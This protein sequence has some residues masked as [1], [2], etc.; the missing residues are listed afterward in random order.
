MSSEAN[1]RLNVTKKS[2]GSSPRDSPHSSLISP[3]P[4]SSTSL[5]KNLSSR[6]PRMIWWGI[7]IARVPISHPCRRTFDRL[8]AQ[9]AEALEAVMDKSEPAVHR[10]EQPEQGYVTYER[11][12]S[13]QQK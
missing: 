13:A 7:M 9:L 1:V 12:R 3:G 8:A 6:L 2:S 11:E 5:E 10:H 4:R